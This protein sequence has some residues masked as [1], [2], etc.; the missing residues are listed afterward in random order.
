MIPYGPSV[1]VFK[2]YVE[3]VR[4]RCSYHPC[5]WAISLFILPLLAIGSLLESCTQKDILYPEQM[6]RLDVRFLWD[7]AK[8]A[9]P[10]GMTLL[11]YP[12]GEREEFWRFEISGRD[13]GPVEI[14]WGTYTLVAVNNDLPATI[15]KDMPYSSASLTARELP[16][17]LT[18]S[19]PVGIVYEAKVE[20]LIVMPHEVS[21]SSADGHMTTD[22]MSVVEC[23]PD[24]IST[25][26]H[27]IFDEVVGIER[28]KS[29]EGV[30]EGCAGGIL[31]S[32]LNPLEPAVSVPFGLDVDVENVRFSG[33]TTGFPNKPSASYGI[34]LRLA[35]YGGGGYEKYFDVTEQVLNSFNKHNVYIIIKGLDLPEER[36]IEPDEV[37]MKV[38]VDGWKVIEINLDSETK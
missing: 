8:E 30:F 6:C 15:L 19:S 13:G 17:A 21:Y 5:G 12:Q 10:E 7:K 2:T 11:F 36:P 33:S 34:T 25:L 31:L 26:Y 3:L 23:Y 37:G 14:P 35:Y 20:T 29:V 16:R 32:S 27:V 38:D 9:D 1:D 24:T 28:V 22:P 18:Y 4:R